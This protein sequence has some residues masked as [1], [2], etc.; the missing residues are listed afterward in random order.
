MN[1]VWDHRPDRSFFKGIVLQEY[2]AENHELLGEPQDMLQVLVVSFG[3]GSASEKRYRIHNLPR[4]WAMLVPNRA[5]SRIEHSGCCK[6]KGY[7]ARS[8]EDWG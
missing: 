3:H 1:M 8:R 2:S 5:K 6:N 7:D 4:V